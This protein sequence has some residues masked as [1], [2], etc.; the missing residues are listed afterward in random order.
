[1]KICNHC[2]LSQPEANF[3]RSRSSKDGL[4]PRCRSCTKE[5]SDAHKVELAARTRRWQREHPERYAELQLKYKLRRT[6][7]HLTTND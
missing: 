7:S 1:M 3:C 2:H 5:Y 6:K 4:N